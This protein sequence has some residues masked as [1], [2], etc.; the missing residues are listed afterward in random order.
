LGSY[1]TDRAVTT[2]IPLLCVHAL[3]R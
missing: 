3:S 1:F 2:N